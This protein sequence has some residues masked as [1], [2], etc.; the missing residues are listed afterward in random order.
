MSKPEAE[1]NYPSS[2]IIVFCF[3]RRGDEVLLVERAFPPYQGMRTIPGG[4]KQFGEEITAACLR[5]M[6]EETG[7]TL[8]DCHLA[9]FMQ[10]HRAGRTGPEALCI[11][12]AAEDF[13][14]ELTP[15]E[16]G[17]L[18][19]TK[20]EAVYRDKGTHP[21]LRALLPHVVSG[22]Y[23]FTAEAY[24]DAEGKGD[25]SITGPGKHGK[26]VRERHE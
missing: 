22:N 17:P 12:Y 3:I 2:T 26:T 13:S 14:G 7:L 6:K 24:V 16:E 8:H 15:S 21:A 25:Y 10:V 19:W 18:A 5:E 9:G 1:K 11:Y 23:P 20:T 4:H